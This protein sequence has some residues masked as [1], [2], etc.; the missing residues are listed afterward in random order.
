MTV[1]ARRSVLSPA[2]RSLARFFRLVS[3]RM[4]Q[5]RTDF[6]LAE[7]FFFLPSGAIEHCVRPS[8]K[9]PRPSC[10]SLISSPRTLSVSYERS[11]SSRFLASRSYSFSW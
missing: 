1:H 3:A 9:T 6:S 8:T 11:T 4:S 7:F 5:P 2:L 10:P